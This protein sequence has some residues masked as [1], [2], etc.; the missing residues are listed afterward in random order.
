MTVFH[1]ALSLPAF[2]SL[3]R[4]ASTNRASP[5]PVGREDGVGK[6]RIG[7]WLRKS[8]LISWGEARSRNREGQA[9][10]GANDVLCMS[11]ERYR[12][13]CPLRF[14]AGA[15]VAASQSRQ[16]IAVGVETGKAIG[17]G[18]PNLHRRSLRVFLHQVLGIPL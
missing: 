18:Q 7:G 11:R 16:R 12:V 13:R 10:G 6:G 14:A 2:S 17:W 1:G 4:A 8:C 3:A 15:C 5:L 9:K